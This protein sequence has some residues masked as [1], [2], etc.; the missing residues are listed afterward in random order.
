VLGIFNLIP[1]PPLDGS[2]VLGAFLPRNAYEK[3]VA[4]DQYGMFLAFLVL[5]LLART[6]VLASVIQGLAKVFL[7]NYNIQFT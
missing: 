1:V 2:R 7:S 4:L 5:F 3:W 6:G